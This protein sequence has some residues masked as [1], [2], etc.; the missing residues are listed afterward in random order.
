MLDNSSLTRL[1]RLEFGENDPASTSLNLSA[2]PGGML[3]RFPEQAL[4]LMTG[5]TS[6]YLQGQNISCFPE[7]QLLR[8]LRRLDVSDTNIS[9]LP[10]SVLFARVGEDDPESEYKLDL[11]VIGTPVSSLLNWSH[12][13]LSEQ[14]DW[15]E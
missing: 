4:R 1:K 12:H 13:G 8:R 15:S 14:F 3:H 6:L 10:P 11:N 9:Y 5:L 2:R 7:V